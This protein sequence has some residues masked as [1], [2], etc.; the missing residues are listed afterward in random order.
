MTRI[1]FDRAA[2]SYDTVRAHPAAVAA[3]IGRALAA[4]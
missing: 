1:S 2:A 3:E 4:G